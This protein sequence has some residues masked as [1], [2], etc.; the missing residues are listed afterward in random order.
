MRANAKYSL[1]FC[2]PALMYAL[3]GGT[4]LAQQLTSGGGTGTGP[5]T[6]QSDIGFVKTIGVTTANG[7]SGTSSGGTD[8]RL[9]LSLAGITPTSVVIS[10]P[11]KGLITGAASVPDITGTQQSGGAQITIVDNETRANLMTVG[12]YRAG[13]SGDRYTTILSTNGQI[14]TN[15]YVTV[16]GLP[17]GSPTYPATNPGMVAINSDVLTALSAYTPFNA[18]QGGLIFEGIGYDGS[19]DVFTVDGTGVVRIDDVGIPSLPQLIIRDSASATAPTAALSIRQVDGESYIGT[20]NNITNA[21]A[22]QIRIDTNGVQINTLKSQPT[23][24]L[25]LSPSA[26]YD[27][28]LNPTSGGKIIAGAQVQLQGYKVRNLPTASQGQEAYVI[29]GDSGLAWGARVT[30]S[31]SGATKYLVWFN[32]SAWTVVGK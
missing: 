28:V 14:F 23:I 12:A 6:S 8:P 3:F 1:P 20:Y 24:P 17:I 9:T 7:I 32:G 21:Q 25:T 10:D 15:G 27:L 4:A 22:N 29:D 16:D 30:N 26:G 13:N 31:G 5:P 2:G 11:T 18:A 19:R